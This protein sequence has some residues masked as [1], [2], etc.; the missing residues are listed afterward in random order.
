M[1]Q[2]WHGLKKRRYEQINLQSHSTAVL[3]S[4]IET[5]ASSFGGNQSDFNPKK[6]LPIQLE[7][8]N[9]PVAKLRRDLDQETIEIIKGLI[10][11]NQIPPLVL[12]DILSL[13]GMREVI[14]QE[15]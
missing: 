2:T 6:F 10:E 15:E 5:I 13:E 8:E 9:S 3:C 7:D 12:R 14:L 1:L 11:S 4:L